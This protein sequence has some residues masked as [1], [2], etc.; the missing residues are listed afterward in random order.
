MYD[1]L[2]T[3]YTFSCPVHGEAHVRL[4]RFRRIDELPGSHAPTVFRI[5]FT[6]GCGHDHPGLVTHD[7]LDWAPLGVHDDAEREPVFHGPAGVRRLELH[8][9]GDVT[10]RDVVDSNHRRAPDRL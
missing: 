5:E 4:S 3:S 7:D 9:N 8:V 6:C 1:A 2:T 10:G